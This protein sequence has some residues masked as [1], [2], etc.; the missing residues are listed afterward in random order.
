MKKL[1]ALMI[2]SGM[3]GLGPLGCSGHFWGGTAVGAVGAG[4]AY[5]IQN[6]RQ[7]DQL[8]DEY[9]KGQISTEEYGARKKQIGKGSIF[10]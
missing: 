1:C 4:A 9:K 6:K 2:I 7:M 10:Y 3:L 5:E 8:E